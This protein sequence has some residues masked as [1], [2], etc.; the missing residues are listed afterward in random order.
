MRLKIILIGLFILS[1][2]G[3]ATPR[4]QTT[5]L[6]TQQLQNKIA[7]L[8]KQLQEKDEELRDLEAEL[9]GV[10]LA[11]GYPTTKIQKQEPK[12]NISKFTLKQVQTAL[13]NAGFYSGPIDGKIG[14]RTKKAIKEFQ[15]ANGLT[16]DGVIGDKTWS[17]LNKYLK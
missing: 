1:L 16:P 6:Q 3:C 11:K 10:H 17:K 14:E 9:E 4:S 7:H 5:N 13:R 8:E 15:R 2:T 12:I